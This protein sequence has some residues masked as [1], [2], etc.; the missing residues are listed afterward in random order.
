MKPQ[1]LP[2]DSRGFPL[3]HPM[4]K[5]RGEDRLSAPASAIESSGR[6][7]HPDPLPSEGRGDMPFHLS[8]PMGEGRGEGVFWFGAGYLAVS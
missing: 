4:G 6:A 3:S 5:G 2:P 1:N 8:H 7:P